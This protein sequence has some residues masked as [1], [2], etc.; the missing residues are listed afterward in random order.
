MD[1]AME[2]GQNWEYGNDSRVRNVFFNEAHILKELEH[3]IY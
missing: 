3:I 1:Q 2:L